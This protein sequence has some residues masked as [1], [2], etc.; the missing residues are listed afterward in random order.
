M[1]LSYTKVFLKRNLKNDTFIIKRETDKFFEKNFRYYDKKIGTKIWID[2]Y[3][4]TDLKRHVPLCLLH[5]ITRG[6]AS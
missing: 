5:K 4:K 2:T 6:V 1:I 3:S